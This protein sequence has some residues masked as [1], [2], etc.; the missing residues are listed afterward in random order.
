MARPRQGYRREVEP[1]L[2]GGRT[3][4]QPWEQTLEVPDIVAS[5]ERLSA[6]KSQRQ[7]RIAQLSLW[8]MQALAYYDRLGEIHYAASFYG[9]AMSKLRLYVGVIDDE[10]EVEPSEDAQAKALLSRVRDPSG[11]RQT[12]QRNYGKLKFVAGETILLWSVVGG[13]ERWEMVS[14]DEVQQTGDKYVRREAP[15]VEPI[16]LKDPDP[17]DP[18]PPQD[19]EGIAYRLWT[20]HPRWSGLPDSPMR[21][22]LT[23]CEEL[24]LL[25]AAVHSAAT[26]RLLKVGILLLAR[27]L[28]PPEAQGQQPSGPENVMHNRFMQDLFKHLSTPIQDPASASAQIPYVLVGELEDVEKGARMLK[29]HEAMEKYPEEALRAECIRRIALGLDLPPEVLLGMT[30]ANHWTAWQVEQQTWKS[31]LL[32]MAEQMCNDLTTAYLQPAA[33]AAKIPNAENLVV[34]Y[35]ATELL[36]SPDKAKDWQKGHEDGVIGDDAYRDAIGADDS[37]KPTEDERRIYLAVALNEPQL[38]PDAYKNL[39]PDPM[40]MLEKQAEAKAAQQPAPGE[41][42]AQGPPDTEKKGPQRTQQQAEAPDRLAASIGAAAQVSFIRCREKAGAVLKSKLQHAD[43]ELNPNATLVAAALTEAQWDAGAFVPEELVAGAARPLALA[44]F[45]WGLRAD[46]SE[47]LAKMVERHAAATLRE[48]SP[49]PL[50]VGFL[51]AV[52]SSLPRE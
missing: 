46:D 38:L 7:S 47:L 8:Q 19:G 30:D 24:V 34:C 21:A 35:D 14:T 44:C 39:L 22:I 6:K 36:A 11:G 10:G 26:S 5:A 45:Q 1:A 29:I 9:N 42:G 49:E 52:Q 12:L 28:L 15:G 13:L 48:E 32:P 33:V 43:V 50:P 23:L 31:H 4:K 18:G 51:A 41:D 40:A 37:H 25:E 2:N 17:N 16:P 27:G 20:P 3:H